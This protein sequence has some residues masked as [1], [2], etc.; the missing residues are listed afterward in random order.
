MGLF[1]VQ[2]SSELSSFALLRASTVERSR[3]QLTTIKDFILALGVK[4]RTF[5]APA[6]KLSHSS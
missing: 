6:T 4:L 5:I 3:M 1:A 2:K